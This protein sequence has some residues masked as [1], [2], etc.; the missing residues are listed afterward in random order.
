[1][2][3]PRVV[4]ISY[5][6]LLEPLGATQILPYV[7]ALAEGYRMTILSFEKPGEDRAAAARLAEA[8]QAQGMTWLR[9]RYHKSPS[10]PATL[11]D[12]ARGL[13]RLA[14]EHAR[15][16]VDL[17]HARGYVPAAIA[18]GLRRRLGIPYLFDV[19]GLQAEESV[20]AGHWSPRGVKFWLTKRIEQRLL[21][22]ADG[23]VTLTEAIRPT[24]LALPGLA[25]RGSL[26]PWEVIPCCAD[27]DHFR[28][29]HE[30]RAG[31]RAGLGLEERTILVYAGSVGTW[32]LVDEMAAFYAAARRTMPGL[33]F[34]WLVNGS[35]RLVRAVLARHGI[36]EGPDALIRQARF[37]EMPDYLSVAD[38]GIAFIR[39]CLSKRSSSPTKFAEY[40]ACG[41][42]L[43]INAGI[44]DA[45][46]L[47]E[48]HGAGVLVRTFTREAYAEAATALRNQLA[49]GRAAFREVAETHFS[50]AQ[51]AV[52][53]YR[54]LYEQL[55]GRP[56][57]VA[58]DG[59]DE[60]AAA[61]AVHAT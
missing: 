28:F 43:V 50:L 34:L 7:R 26:P 39:P 60:A 5:N 21:R 37:E 1:M 42:P 45:D 30:A 35:P 29:R 12:I 48:Q 31:L 52:P 56:S 57:G 8:L 17:V 51:R 32:Y 13:R 10:L 20:D 19:R 61:H 14:R 18:W 59:V 49:R 40:L 53:A 27:L 6:G 54:R 46:R 25:G 9:E 24:V 55:L 11:Y 44:G 2:T 4:F 58:Q 16:P 36:A 22:D 23:L 47:V 15:E 41:L 38:A 3:H 33:F